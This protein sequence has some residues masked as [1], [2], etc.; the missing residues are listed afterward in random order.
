MFSF[1]THSFPT[2]HIVG[3]PE[4]QFLPLDEFPLSELKPAIKNLAKQLYKPS[5]WNI[6]KDILPTTLRAIWPITAKKSLQSISH[7]SL[8]NAQS[9]IN[10]L[11]N[12]AKNKEVDVIKVY[13]GA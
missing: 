11:V 3:R 10:L 5:Q 12:E 8:S 4:R 6:S 13:P 1:N 7:L 2:S 9:I